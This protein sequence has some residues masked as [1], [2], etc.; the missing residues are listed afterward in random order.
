V[1]VTFPGSSV[2]A[3]TDTL[4]FIIGKGGSHSSRALCTSPSPVRPSMPVLTRLLSSLERVGHIPLGPR[5]CHLPRF[6]CRCLRRHACLRHRKGW[7]AFLSGLL[8]FVC[9]SFHP[10]RREWPHLR[11]GLRYAFCHASTC[12][13]MF[14]ACSQLPPLS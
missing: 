7:V 6:I 11:G 10:W 9:R 2:D 8:R 4:A 14:L 12:Q 1:H 3:G 5:A 13:L